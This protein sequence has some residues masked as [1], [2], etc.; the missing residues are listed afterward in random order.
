MHEFIKNAFFIQ[1][2]SRNICIFHFY[3]VLLQSNYEGSPNEGS[4][5]AYFFALFLL[6]CKRKIIH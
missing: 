2:K 3:F 4:L 5:L 1:K 6:I